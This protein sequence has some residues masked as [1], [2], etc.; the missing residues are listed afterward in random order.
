M[1]QWT[2]LPKN[3]HPARFAEVHECKT[4]NTTFY[5]KRNKNDNAFHCYQ[6]S[7]LIATD[8]NNID[9]AKRLIAGQVLDF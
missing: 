5:I 7:V 6:D 4:K 9:S 8:Y 1:M 2:R 3:E